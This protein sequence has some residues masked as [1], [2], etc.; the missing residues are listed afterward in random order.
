LIIFIRGF[1][2]KKR[3]IS[4]VDKKIVLAIDDVIVQL[5]LFIRILTPK[6]DVRV[7][8]SAADAL[9]Y[10]NSN[11]ADVILLDIE[12]PNITGFDFLTDIRKVPSYMT[13]PIIIV[14][15]KTGREFFEQAKKSSAFDVL[16]KPV[17]PEN[18]IETIE[19]ALASKA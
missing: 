11:K 9:N 17:T 6:Y 18:L 2:L 19:K 16:S 13:V 12:M 7:V 5:E 4:G 3:G 14:S 1:I 8:K 15:G 10:L